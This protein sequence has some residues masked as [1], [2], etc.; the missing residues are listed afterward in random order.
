MSKRRRGNSA[1]RVRRSKPRRAIQQSSSSP[2]VSRSRRLRRAGS[3]P[4]DQQHSPGG[5]VL[6][7]KPNRGVFAAAGARRRTT[8]TRQ[9]GNRLLRGSLL[10]GDNLLSQRR[11]HYGLSPS[12]VP[13]SRRDAREDRKKGYRSLCQKKAST[14]RAVIIATGHGGLNG[15][16][17]YKKQETN[18]CRQ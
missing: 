3:Y 8:R 11:L 10:R 1:A 5:A 6:H 16:R 15:V 7:G 9:T 12:A 13:I 18:K 17:T 2:P 14:R 4:P